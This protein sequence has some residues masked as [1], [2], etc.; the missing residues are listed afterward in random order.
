MEQPAT[1]DIDLIV[2]RIKTLYPDFKITGITM[3][4]LD[5]MIH[6]EHNPNIPGSGST[7]RWSVEDGKA[8]FKGASS[9]K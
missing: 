6:V 5:Y 3:E 1:R 2:E 8:V 7:Q 9:N 4:E